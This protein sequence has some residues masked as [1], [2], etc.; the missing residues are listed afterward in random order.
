MAHSISR[1]IRVRALDDTLTLHP[2]EPTR[3]AGEPQAIEPHNQMDH[4]MINHSAPGKTLPCLAD[5]Q[6]ILEQANL[7]LAEA[8]AVADRS[9][10][11]MALLSA[12]EPTDTECRSSGRGP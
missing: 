1:F 7:L 2:G 9:D 10:R 6:E 5:R 3:A 8:R 4:G 11:T 12:E